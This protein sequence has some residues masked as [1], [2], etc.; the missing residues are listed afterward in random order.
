VW[1]DQITTK[2]GRKKM[3]EEKKKVERYERDKYFHWSD[4]I[5]KVADELTYRYD[6][7]KLQR[8]FMASEKKR[9]LYSSLEKMFDAAPMDA[10]DHQAYKHGGVQQ[11]KTKQDYVEWGKRIAIERGIP[12]YNRE[13]GIPLGQRYIEPVLISGTEIMIDH[14]D[15]NFYNNP[16]IHQMI[17][18]V[19]RTVI[20]GLDVPHRVI[21]LRLGKEISPESMNLFMET[22]QHTLSGGA[23][24]QE[25]MA[26]SHPGLTRDAYAK[27]TT[28]NDE[29]IEQFDKRWVLDPDKECH[30]ER[31][32]MLKYGIG[33][34]LFT[35]NRC[36]TLR[37][38]MADGGAQARASAIA[39]TMSFVAAYRLIGESVLSDIAYATRHAQ[40]IYMGLPTWYSRARPQNEPGGVPF[41]YMADFCTNE[42]ELPATPFL[43]VA[44]TDEGGAK[45]LA[46]AIVEWGAI[47]E[48]FTDGAW[49]GIYMSGGL[50]FP[51]AGTILI[52]G[53]AVRDWLY[54]AVELLYTNWE[55]HERMPS[56]WNTI[57]TLVEV[58]A[59][60]FMETFEKYPTL[61]EMMW[62]GGLRGILIGAVASAVAAATTGDSMLGKQAY[63]Y[64]IGF[65]E[66]EGWMRTGWG[67]QEVQEHC[68]LPFAASLRIEE[69][70]LPEL[71]GMNVPY[72]SY[73]AAHNLAVNCYC[74]ML[75]RGS[76][77]AC[78]PLVK[79]AFAD[80]D[81]VFD[82]RHPALTVAKG[83]LHQ[84]EPAGERDIVRPAR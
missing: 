41:G 29:L 68:G 26:E 2:K 79:I 19:K 32:E 25:H 21:Q 53:N 43:K 5:A 24:I 48:P 9:E 63:H 78:S 70:G 18:D 72:I 44:S 33:D 45:R 62:G 71:I 38:R 50:G 11:S 4:K 22:M 12:S 51:S 37:G 1:E 66:K 69:G 83:G 61:Y 74:A 84:F 65:I 80:P 35:V 54:R 39:V 36:H 81:L 46:D 20:V 17:D 59:T 57:K 52:H 16:A 15:L 23:V 76:A 28:G 8:Q 30:P 64:A 82:F 56:K 67:G 77:W 31:A 73:T 7:M 10:V 75:G 60:Y 58:I 6:P 13:M 27:I 34:R 47:Q 49:Y 42:V 3:E 40:A 14:D 55:G